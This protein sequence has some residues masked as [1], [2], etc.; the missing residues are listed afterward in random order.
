MDRRE[1]GGCIEDQ[2]RGPI[3]DAGIGSGHGIWRG[4]RTGLPTALVASNKANDAPQA[5]PILTRGMLI[6]L[7]AQER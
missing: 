3:E 4:R 1:A 2:L 5:K 7:R 6:G